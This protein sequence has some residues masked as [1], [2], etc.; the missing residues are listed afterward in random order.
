[1]DERKMKKILIL[2]FASLCLLSCYKTEITNEP[3]PVGHIHE[4]YILNDSTTY[5]MNCNMFREYVEMYLVTKAKR[6][7]DTKEIYLFDKIYYVDDYTILIGR[8]AEKFTPDEF[9]KQLIKKN[10]LTRTEPIFEFSNNIYCSWTMFD[11]IYKLYV[12]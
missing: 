12:R 11:K 8:D 9:K 7:I 6:V 5:Y 1:M 4:E 10:K 2:I 3:I